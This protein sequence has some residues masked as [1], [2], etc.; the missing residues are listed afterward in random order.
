LRL[1]KKNPG[2]GA[3]CKRDKRQRQQEVKVGR[4]GGESDADSE[5]AHQHDGM[6]FN[7][8]EGQGKKKGI[9]MKAQGAPRD[10]RG[11]KK[12]K[13]K[14]RRDEKPRGES[15]KRRKAGTPTS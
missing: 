13:E 9:S 4:K 1:R 12:E 2:G 15:K 7:D 10:P 6:A 11:K 8:R 14:K 3:I 5:V